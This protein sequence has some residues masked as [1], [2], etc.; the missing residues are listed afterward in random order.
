M[1]CVVRGY[2]SGAVQDGWLVYFNDL[3]L[4]ATDALIGKLAMLETADG[5]KLL[6][7]IKRGRKPNTWDLFTVTG[8]AMLDVDLAWAQEVL[9]I[10]PHYT[11]SAD[12]LAA[13][14]TLG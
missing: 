14:E 11:W 3:K 7:T 10:K 12:D 13:I 2:N 4:P 1:A 6:R 5:R 9:W 8:P